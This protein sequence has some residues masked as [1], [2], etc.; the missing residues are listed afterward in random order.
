MNIGI[1]CVVVMNVVCDQ[2][3]G[4]GYI[5][6]VMIVEWKDQINEL[7]VDFLEFIEMRI[8]VSKYC[9]LECFLSKC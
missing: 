9:L 5:D 4:I 3:I 8:K 2:L 7:W 1:E 6:V